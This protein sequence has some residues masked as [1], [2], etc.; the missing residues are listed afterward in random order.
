[1]E[2]RKTAKK[3]NFSEAE[4]EVITTEVE[5]NRIILFGSLK[6]GIKGTQ[7]NAVWAKITAAVNS[8]GVDARSPAEV[9]FYFL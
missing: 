8:V 2:T 3:R 5:R 9:V 4:I 6:S 1:M 7:K